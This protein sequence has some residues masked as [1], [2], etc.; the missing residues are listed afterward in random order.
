[1]LTHWGRV[2]HICFSKLSITGSDNGLLPGWCQ[3]IIWTNTGILVIE[4]L[5]TNPSEILIKIHTFS[6]KKMHLKISSGKCRPFCLGLNMLMTMEVRHRIHRWLKG[7]QICIFWKKIHKFHKACNWMETKYC[8]QTV[9]VLKKVNVV[10]HIAIIKDIQC[11]FFPMKYSVARLLPRA[12]LASHLI[13]STGKLNWMKWQQ[14]YS[15]T[16]W[17]DILTPLYIDPGV[18]ISY[19]I[20]IPGSL[21]RNHIL[22]PLTIF[23][24]PSQYSI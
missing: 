6:F 12:E 20:L 22:T 19:D 1:M 16:V 24:P 18:N 14:I 3:A 10:K 5:G 9:I 15:N 23:W 11:C 8:E 21:Y 17:D 13:N 7:N 2:T 4:P